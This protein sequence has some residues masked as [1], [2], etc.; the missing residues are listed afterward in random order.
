MFVSQLLSSD[1][2]PKMI[3]FKS[4]EIADFPQNN[5]EQISGCQNKHYLEAEGTVL[6]TPLI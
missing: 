6:L 3:L 2:I 1:A 4:N 5:Q